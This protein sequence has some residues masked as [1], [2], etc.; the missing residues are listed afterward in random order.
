VLADLVQ[1]ANKRHRAIEMGKAGT[2]YR[3]WTPTTEAQA[4]GPVVPAVVVCFCLH[5][6]EETCLLCILQLR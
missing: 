4:A 1:F 5:L 3:Y 2:V 6:F